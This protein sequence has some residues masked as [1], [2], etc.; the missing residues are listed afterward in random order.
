MNGGAP[1]AETLADQLLCYQ[2]TAP[3]SAKL[4]PVYLADELGSST[5]SVSRA[6]EVCL[7]ATLGP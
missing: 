6:E 2:V 1:G 3:K 7:P 5:V 4:A